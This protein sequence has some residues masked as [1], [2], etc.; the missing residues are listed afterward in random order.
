MYEA[1]HRH[2]GRSVA[3][4]ISSAHG[5]HRV[6]VTRHRRLMR[7][8]RILSQLRHP[9]IVEILDAG[10]I[11]AGLPSEH[12]FLVC[13]LL[14]G[15]TVDALLGA[16]GVFPVQAAITIAIDLCSAVAHA[17]RRGV[18]H[19]DIKPANVFVV[20][21]VVGAETVKL[22][23]FGVGRSSELPDAKLTADGGIVGTPAYMSPEALMGYELDPRSDVY[24][25]G[26]LLYECLS[27][28]VVHPGNY[29]AMIR[30]ASTPGPTPRIAAPGVDEAIE[31]VVA[32]SLAR[33]RDERY[34]SAEALGEA[35]RGLGSPRPLRVLEL[36]SAE[37]RRRHHRVPFLSPVAVRGAE[38]S[39]DGRCEDISESGMLFLS[40][41]GCAEGAKYEVRFGAPLSGRVMRSRAVARWVRARAVGGWAIGF[42][43][44]DTPDDLVRDIGAFVRLMS[45]TPVIDVGPE[46]ESAF[47]E[48]T[49]TLADEGAKPT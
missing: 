46:S 8:A 25:V 49:P 14:E 6:R 42:E 34:P 18:L 2:L 28:R 1:V 17:H 48:I 9:N 27:G 40:Q 29:A 26:A 20:R 31:R 36:P 32:K 12:P 23:D 39:L 38:Q 15:K 33:D 3:L 35:L 44:I 24:S 19:R 30:A 47:R 4:K 13:E 22:L 7:E 16:R 41:S 5:P 45:E 11:D 43:F 21:Q 10:L 37:Q